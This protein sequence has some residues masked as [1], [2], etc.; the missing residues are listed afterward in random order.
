MEEIW[1]D[2]EGFNGA[3]MISN[4][5]NIKSLL[6]NKII[7]QQKINSGYLIAH[8]R[9]NGNRKAITTHRLVAKAFIQNLENK[10]QVNHLDGNK[11]NNH[12]NNLEWCTQS[13]N[14]KHAYDSGIIERTDDWNNKI[15]ESQIGEKN[16][17]SVLTMAKVIQ[18]K[19]YINNG[20]SNAEIA[21]KYN[22][23]SSTIWNIKVG[24]S[25]SWV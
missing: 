15:A 23:G 25:W 8:L 19:K 16:N 1:K 5:G 13:E 6:S 24:N 10:P 21:E 9:F 7:R 3:Y 4:F 22:C 12:I 18:I 11:E 2:I 14:I 17:V 20:L